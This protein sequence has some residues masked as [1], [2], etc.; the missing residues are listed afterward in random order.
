MFLCASRKEMWSW[1]L[2]CK[3]AVITLTLCC[4]GGRNET[5]TLEEEELQANEVQRQEYH[6]EIIYD[7]EGVDPSVPCML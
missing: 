7:D 3:N 5:S 4:N 1:M 2:V 6:N